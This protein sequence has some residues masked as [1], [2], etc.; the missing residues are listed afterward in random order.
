MR[1]LI[2]VY[3]KTG[4]V[5][6]AQ[7]LIELDWEIISTGGTYRLLTDSG[8]TVTEVSESTGFPDMLDGRVKTL[9]PNIHGGI[10]YRRGDEQ[11]EA[12]I[13][14]LGIQSIDMIVNSLYPFEETVNKP[15]MTQAEII[16]QIDI[17]GPAMIRAASKNYQDVIVVIDKNDYADIIESLKNNTMDIE[18]RRQLAGKAFSL[19]AYYD[20]Q[21]AHYFNQTNDIDFPKYFTQA[22]QFQETLRYGENPHQKAA[23]YRESHPMYVFNQLH[24]KQISYNNMND[25]NACIALVHEFTDPVAVAVK[26][27]N[28]CGVAVGNTIA[29][30]Y[31]KAYE[32]DPESIF[33]G[34]I[35]LN[36]PVDKD[37]ATKLS[38]IF[39]EIVA[40]PSFDQE[41][42]AILTKKK[43]IR[44]IEMPNLMEAAS[45]IM[46]SKETINGVLVQETDQALYDGQ[47][48]LM[49]QRT[50][51]TSEQ[52]DLDFAWKVVKH[53][54][55]NAM[56][57]AKDGMT[58][59]LG[60]GEVKR[61]WA[62]EKALERSE[63]DLTGAVVA[64][65]A[66]FFKDTIET[67]AKYG[68]KA[69]IQPGGSVKDSEVINEANEKNI[70]VLFTGMRH[71]KH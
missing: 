39:L 57:V 71:F 37:T 33:G 9:H 38:E 70:S 5:E 36:R 20:A 40:A 7:H 44:L 24:G 68:I 66:F 64:S 23:L 43:N 17:G 51:T 52:Q 69:V 28:P 61:V 58:Y 59:G 3:D 14:E 8:I 31:Q 46:M 35:G 12:T 45:P 65:D 6:F 34:I 10:L 18:K 42:L 16:E 53:I 25:L 55:S 60:H 1:A 13:E 48:Q 11:H 41:A 30:A 50:V 67:L 2:S 15:N 22:Y 27:A 32:C 49:T 63:F 29:E 54:A 62:L 4:I 26:H 47:P 56:V 21:I 19:T